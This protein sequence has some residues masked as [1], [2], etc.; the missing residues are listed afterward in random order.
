[1]NSSRCA[2]LDASRK[3]TGKKSFDASPPSGVSSRLTRPCRSAASSNPSMR[4]STCWIFCASNAVASSSAICRD[5][6]LSNAPKSPIAPST[7]ADIPSKIS[8][9]N[10][11]R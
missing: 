2:K 3:N 9:R 7:T 5:C 1:M 8:V 4:P 11:H 10:D 6:R